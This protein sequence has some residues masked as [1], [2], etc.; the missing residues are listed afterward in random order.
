MRIE[1]HLHIISPTIFHY[2]L[3]SVASDW[4]K[5]YE[6]DPESGM[7]ELVQFFVL[8]CACRAEITLEMY[9]AEVTEVIRT[10]TENFVED[11]GDYP[12]IMTGPGQKKFKVSH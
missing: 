7:L 11:S 12:L 4:V 5:R 2:N 6:Q 3:Q 1:F 10:L 9:R 8:C